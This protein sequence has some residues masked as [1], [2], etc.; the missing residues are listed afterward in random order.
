VIADMASG[1]LLSD[2]VILQIEGWV[3]NWR[4]LQSYQS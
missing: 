2:M 1:G 4:R 3:L